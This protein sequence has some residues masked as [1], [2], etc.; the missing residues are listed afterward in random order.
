MYS[1]LRKLFIK[2]NPHALRRTLSGIDPPIQN[3]KNNSQIFLT[4][5]TIAG[6]GLF[7]LNKF[8]VPDKNI[9]FLPVQMPQQTDQ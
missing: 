1:F 8:G 4:I 7:S 2:S 9:N 6:L 5:L 3:K